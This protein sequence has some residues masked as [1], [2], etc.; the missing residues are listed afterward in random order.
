MINFT[1]YTSDCTGN[2]LNCIYPKK[3]KIMD[4]DSMVEAIKFDHV[5][6]KYKGNYRNVANFIQADCAVLDCDNA[7]SDDP[8]VWVTAADVAATFQD[9][10][11]IAAYS[12]NHMKQKDNKSP[13]QDFMSIL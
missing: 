3:I 9:V 6:A 7:H 12:R 13:R 10:P 11:F 5:T 4:K 1:L 8:E 2:L